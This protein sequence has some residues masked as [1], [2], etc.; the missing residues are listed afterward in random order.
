M[1]SARAALLCGFILSGCSDHWTRLATT[2]QQADA[3]QY[4][5]QRENRYFSDG[6]VLGPQGDFA[7]EDMIRQCMRARGYSTAR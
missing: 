6:G 2:Q 7:Q 4:Q 5:C 1:T 3:D